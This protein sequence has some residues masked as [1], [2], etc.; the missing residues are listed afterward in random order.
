[1]REFFTSGTVG[2]APGNWCLYPERS[3]IENPYSQENMFKNCGK[4]KPK[5]VLMEHYDS[6]K[7]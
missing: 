3:E 1:M 6:R 4:L 2:R 7:E 5:S